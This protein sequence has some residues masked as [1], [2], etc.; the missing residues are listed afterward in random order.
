MA[1]THCG[2]FPSASFKDLKKQVAK[3][4]IKNGIMG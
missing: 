4:N 1:A 3:Q 2:P